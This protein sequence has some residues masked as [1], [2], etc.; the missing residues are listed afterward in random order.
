MTRFDHRALKDDARKTLSSARYDPKRLITIHAGTHCLVTAAVALVVFF[1]NGQIAET[2]GLG[3]LGQR[4]L[5]TTIRTVLQLAQ[6]IFL[7]FWS[8]GYVSASIDLARDHSP[9]PDMLLDGFRKWGVCL[10]LMLLHILIFG[11]VLFFSTQA[12]SFLFC[13][14]PWA[15][16][17]VEFVQKYGAV[18]QIPDIEVIEE[19]FYAV[20]EQIQV[21]LMSMASGVFL[22]AALPFAY[23]FRLSQLQL[24]D[25][26]GAGALRALFGSG[27]LMKG[28]Y[29]A[30]IRLDL[31][32]WW[33]HLG[34]LLIYLLGN[35][36]PI[37]SLLGIRLS[38]VSDLF[39]LCTTLISAAALFLLC[40]WN[41]NEVSVAYVN[42]YDILQEPPREEP[43]PIPGF[44]PW[45]Y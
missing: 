38:F 31:H 30:M 16:P 43:R 25:D 17:L 12:A 15:A 29:G 27:K 5:L 34:Y 13:M 39:I 45:N 32:F 35:I 18:T 10:R 44:Q 2:G 36:G 9:E 42:A 28:S 11:G 3:G 14:T 4:S 20:V 1:L 24:M 21:P 22:I 23:R 40:W 41:K 33:Y 19:T 7:P 37:C 6:M 26:P 8:I